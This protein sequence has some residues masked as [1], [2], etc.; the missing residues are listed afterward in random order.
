MKWIKDAIYGFVGIENSA[1]SV[2][3]SKE[4]QRLRWIKQL[5][6]TNLVYPSASH[7]RF[8]HSLGSY[9][10]ACKIC[11]YLNIEKE[12][13]KIAALLHDIGH[14]P[15]SHSI[16]KLVERHEKIGVE[17]I[18][19]KLSNILENNGFDVRKVVKYIKGKNKYGKIISGELDV[20]RLDYL[21]R[22]SY[23]TGVAYGVID[24]QAIIRG[25]EKLGK[26]I[27]IKIEY[28]PACE[29]ILIARYLMYSTV[30]YHHTVR[31]IL[32]M[33]RRAFQEFSLRHEDLE[34]IKFF[35]DSE[36]IEL[37]KQNPASKSFIEKILERRLFKEVMRIYVD[38]KTILEFTN[39]EKCYEVENEIAEKLKIKKGGILIHSILPAKFSESKIVISGSNKTLEKISPLVRA[40]NDAVKNYSWIGIYAEKPLMKN[41]VNKV[42]KKYF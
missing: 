10:L 31:I 20:D 12:E 9:Y 37:L 22:D 29:S 26:H 32:A 23:Y 17:I 38:E 4:F 25:I 36:L 27:K 42:V 8:E 40:L 24:Y 14:L 30:Y 15:F 3:E 19:S 39:P 33:L 1:L 5:G 18:K 41:A 11:E 21:N 16:E 28:L 7:T 34:K 6:L 13:L 35:T 2:I